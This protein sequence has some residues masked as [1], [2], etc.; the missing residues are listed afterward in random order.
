MHALSGVRCELDPTEWMRTDLILN[1]INGDLIEVHHGKR[2]TLW[3][4]ITLQ[5]AKQSQQ[6]HKN[7]R[8]HRYDWH[9]AWAYAL[10]LR[11]DDQ[12][13]WTQHPRD[14]KQPLP[15]LRKTVENK[16]MEWFSA[17]G[18]VPH[19]IDIRWTLTG[20]LYA[21]KKRLKKRKR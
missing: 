16:I 20:P 17:H 7:K 18:G 19:I 14:K 3:S 12:W 13:D 4:S 15:A 2:T 9:G 11:A 6:K 1:V 21:G 8:A 10:T 5:Q